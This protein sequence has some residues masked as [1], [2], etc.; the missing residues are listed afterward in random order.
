MDYPVTGGMQTSYLLSVNSPLLQEQ[1]IL[2]EVKDLI[3][4]A[5]DAARD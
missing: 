5:T 3:Q 1:Q 2:L 4:K